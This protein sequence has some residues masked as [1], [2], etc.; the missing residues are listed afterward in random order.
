MTDVRLTT[1][2]NFDFTK[3]YTAKK[4]NGSTKLDLYSYTGRV[5]FFDKD[6][7]FGY[8]KEIPDT[9][10]LKNVVKEWRIT[11]EQL[12]NTSIHR[13]DFVYFM[14]HGKTI[15]EISPINLRDLLKDPCP[16]CG[17]RDYVLGKNSACEHCGHK[18]KTDLNQASNTKNTNNNRDNDPAFNCLVGTD[19]DIPCPV[20]GRHAWK[21]YGVQQ[22]LGCR[23]CG[24]LYP[25]DLGKAIAIFVFLAI[26]FFLLYFFFFIILK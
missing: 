7:G 10:N 14:K 3:K 17:R 5:K 6:K 26:T 13:G 4:S 9:K 20:C 12:G 19:R 11:S 22:H 21:R 15:G 8:I 25:S 16:K 18:F 23:C 1:P 2:T 24:S